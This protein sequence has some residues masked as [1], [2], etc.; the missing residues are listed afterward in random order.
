VVEDYASQ[1]PFKFT[2]TPD[3]LTID[4]K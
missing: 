2:G 1:M 3:K 4:L